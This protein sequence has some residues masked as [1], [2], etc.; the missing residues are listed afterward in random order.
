ME[1]L[2]LDLSDPSLKDTPGRVAKMYNREIFSGLNKDN[3]PKVTKFPN[4]KEKSQMVIVDNI[5]VKSTCEHHFL[6]F[7]GVAH[8]AY[9]PSKEIAG[10]SKLARVVNFHCKK[11]QVQEKLGEEILDSLKKELDTDNVALIIKSQHYCMIMRGVE[12]PNSWTTT[13]HLGGLFLEKPEVR[14]E[15]LNLI[16]Q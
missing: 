7:I 3:F 11:P 16:K 1:I 13:S 10:L 12:E 5:A 4:P 9:I 8:V 14:Q 6:P 15:F 2:G